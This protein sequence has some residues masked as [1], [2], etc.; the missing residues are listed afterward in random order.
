MNRIVCITSKQLKG[1]E[2]GGEAKKK[3]DKQKQKN[4]N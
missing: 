4:I 3:Y 1:K 2:V